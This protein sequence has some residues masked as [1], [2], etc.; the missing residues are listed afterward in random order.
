M[1]LLTKEDVISSLTS[2][3]E[4]TLIYFDLDDHLL[5]RTYG[6]GKWSI[7]EILHH[8]C[9]AELIFLERLKRIIAEPKQVIWAYNQDM[10]NA[11]FDYANSPLGDKKSLYRMCREFNMGLVDK[12]YE[13]LGDK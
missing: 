6:D 13:V 11:A 5:K 4:Q 3:M 8:L 1:K 2:T 12:Y 7:S 10:W 9:D